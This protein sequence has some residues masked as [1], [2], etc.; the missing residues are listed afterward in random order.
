MR[1]HSNIGGGEAVIFFSDD[2]EPPR[3][4]L[5]S[6]F[7]AILDAVVGL[8][9]FAEQT[10]RA[11]FIR[12]DG[13]LCIT[14]AVFFTLPFDSDGV[15]DHSWNIPLQQL[16][17]SAGSGPDLGAGPI[18]LTCRSQCSVAWHQKQLWDPQLDGDAQE[19]NQLI[20]I[21]NDNRL[22]IIVNKNRDG[23]G[24][25]KGDRYESTATPKSFQQ[26]IDSF[27]IS[28]Q[29][30]HIPILDQITSMPTE[31]LKP[32]LI[33][34]S[35]SG[36]ADTGW[37]QEFLEENIRLELTQKISSIYQKKL[38]DKLVSVLKD[39]DLAINALTNQQSDDFK[40]YKVQQQQILAEYVEK[41]E[42]FEQALMQERDKNKDLK[43]KLQSQATEAHM[44]RELFEDEMA[45]ARHVKDS[46]LVSIKKQFSLEVKTHVEAETATLK[47]V[48]KMRE[49][50]LYYRHEQELTLRDA[51]VRLREEKAVMI[52]DKVSDY[53]S[54][55][56]DSDITFVAYHSGAGHITV[57]YDEM[58]KYL[59]NTNAYAAERCG[60]DLSLYEEWVEHFDEPCCQEKLPSG[61]LCGKE[62]DQ[63]DHP[64]QFISSVSTRCREHIGLNKKRLI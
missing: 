4:M 28:S 47:E 31:T 46:D 25:G 8:S 30:Q 11:A 64:N 34:T 43:T 6:E 44:S 49:I 27:Q 38:K 23:S 29:Q 36:G 17:D 48:L 33:N 53:I 57:P 39:H 52:N 59:E 12:I 37:D 16:A 22:G 55:L 32:S 7:E 62:I 10:K 9:E 61:G 21:A 42:L 60:V 18:R 50:E 15:P 41:L 54:K 40:T 24:L 20:R 56:R 13:R 45:E 5:Y 63:V 19:F 2:N 3:E 1:L 58:G 35:E 14:A 51:V 26:P